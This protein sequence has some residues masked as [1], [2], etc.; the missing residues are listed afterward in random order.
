MHREFVEKRI[1]DLKSDISSGGL[2]EALVRAALYVGMSVGTI[3]ERTF[4]LVRRIRLAHDMPSATLAEFKKIVREQYYMLLFD[5][6]AALAALPKLLPAD[7]EERRQALKVLDDVLSARGALAEEASG[8]YREI[9]DLFNV[10]GKD[11]SSFA[12]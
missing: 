1:A 3:D 11:Q 5:R 6:E 10:G 2:R 9:A 4:E 12:A 8:R 7:R